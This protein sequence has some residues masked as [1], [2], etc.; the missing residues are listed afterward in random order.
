KVAQL[1]RRS[2]RPFSSSAAIIFSCL[3]QWLARGIFGVFRELPPAEQ[4]NTGCYYSVVLG[5]CLYYVFK[6]VQ[7]SATI[8]LPS[9]EPES[10]A[11]FQE[12]AENSSWPILTHFLS[13]LFAA[14]A[15]VIG[16]ITWIEKAN[17]HGPG[18]N[19][20]ALIIVLHLL[21]VTAS[22]LTATMEFGSCS[23]L[24]SNGVVRFSMFIPTMNNFVSLLC[25]LTIFSTV[26]STLI[27]TQSHAYLALEI[28]EI[29]KPV[30]SS[31][32]RLDL[33]LDSRLIRSVSASFGSILCVLFFL[34]FELRLE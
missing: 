22:R 15:C 20:A 5:W 6:S 19:P 9:S 28:V 31:L 3:G 27:Q 12:F 16:G 21:L 26:F 10:L 25:A 4:R 18:A 30:G 29:I 1:R 8:G 34:C 7:L 2:R 32:H 11:V 13:I 17:R 33:H 14:G 23:R 24:I